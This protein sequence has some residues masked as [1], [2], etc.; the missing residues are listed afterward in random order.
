MYNLILMLSLPQNLLSLGSFFPSSLAL[1]FPQNTSLLFLLH[2]DL[3]HLFCLIFYSLCKPSL[4]KFDDAAK[5]GPF[6][7]S[8]LGTGQEP[9]WWLSDSFVVNFLMKHIKLTFNEVSLQNR[10]LFLLWYWY[11]PFVLFLKAHI[12]ESP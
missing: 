10:V 12:P 7:H 2:L 4:F 11:K 3:W 9:S 1:A 6:L 8:W 5:F